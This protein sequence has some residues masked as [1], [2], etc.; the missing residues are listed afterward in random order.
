MN[1]KFTFLAILLTSFICNAQ[2]IE[3]FS[4]D[5]G[6]ASVTIG[7][8]QILYT[9]GEVNVQEYS[10]ATL[11]ISEGF[12]NPISLM[13]KLD[14]KI[15]LEGPYT[16]G[17]MTDALRTNDFIPTT[18]P[19]ADGA[20]CNAT[21]FDVTGSNAII[22]W[23]WIEIRDNVDNTVV[24]AQTSALLQADGDV[25]ATDGVSAVP[26]NAPAGTY[27]I[28]LSHRNHL[29]IL[30]ANTVSLSGSSTAID[31]TSDSSLITGGANGIANMGDGRYALFAG[32][33]DGNGQVQ[34]SDVSGVLPFI[35]L[36]DYLNADVDMNSQAQNTDIFNTVHPNIEKGEQFARRNL[37]LFAKR[38]PN[39]DDNN[40]Q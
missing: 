11:S 18:S 14:P 35:G 19:Y 22:D 25:V 9:I 37:S 10:T 5:S 15:F 29:G 36:S 20:I 26:V 6:G 4:I 13:I 12:I 24:I 21:V 16:S 34:N 28:M 31:L 40:N 39:K 30:T 27:Y 38:R 32:D 17:I 8:I 1:T 33:F 3:K 2:T 7:D 23:V